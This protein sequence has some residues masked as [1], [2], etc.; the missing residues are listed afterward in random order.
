V[1]VKLMMTIY[2][3]ITWKIYDSLLDFFK[4]LYS[5]LHD[6]ETIKNLMVCS[7]ILNPERRC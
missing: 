3:Y 1:R 4:R 6:V 5:T 2:Y 7:I